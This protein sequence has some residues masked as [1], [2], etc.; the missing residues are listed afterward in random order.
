MCVFAAALTMQAQDVVKVAVGDTQDHGVTYSLPKTQIRVTVKARCTTVKAGAYAQYAEKYLGL[1]DA[2]LD[3]KTEW[4]ISSVTLS[5]EA[6]ADT[7]RTFH[8]VFNEKMPLPT[9][10]FDAEGRLL[11][12]NR[13][14]GAVKRSAADEETTDAVTEKKTV[15]AFNVMSEE[16]LKAGSKA[17]QAEIAARQIFR[18]RESRLNLLTGEVDK[19]PADGASFQ[20]VM[21]NLKQQEDAYMQLFCGVTTET[22]VER[23]FI[24]MPMEEEQGVILFRFSKHFGFADADDLSGEPYTVSLTLLEDNRKV[25]ERVDAKGKKLPPATGIAHCVAGKASVA[26]IHKGK[27]LAE[28]NWQM[29]QF[30]HVENLDK[31]HFL[32]KK[33]PASALFN[34]MTGAVT[35]F[36]N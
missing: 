14:P 22:E 4:S 28:D 7:S 31:M 2:L 33:T 12:I 15:S 3:D 9:F 21:D 6:V 18:I 8:I 25:A 11:S 24:Y 16:L 17:K 10:Y 20:I 26:L 35:L 19:M 32:N 29:G 5:P 30:G 1:T 34:P 36:N 13:E 23:E 27:T